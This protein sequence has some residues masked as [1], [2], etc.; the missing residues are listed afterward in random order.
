MYLCS[1]KIKTRMKLEMSS[2][3]NPTNSSIDN[4]SGGIYFGN[5]ATVQG[6]VVGGD[7]NTNTTS[8]SGDSFSKD[9]LLNLL[10]EL[11]ASIKQASIDEDDKDV[12]AGQIATAISE[13]KKS[14]VNNPQEAKDK[15]GQYLTDTKSILDRVKDVGE[16]GSK[17]FPILVK[18]A[19]LVGLSII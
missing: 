9:E 15:I 12:A 7:K 16:I 14:D 4:R 11:K 3:K 18:V 17:A 2:E 1:W 19:K 5:K 10:K 6:D 13:T 8:S